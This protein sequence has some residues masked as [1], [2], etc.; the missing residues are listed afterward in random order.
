MRSVAAW[1]TTARE[2]L[3]SVS[4]TAPNTVWF[5]TPGIASVAAENDRLRAGH[6]ATVA[7]SLRALAGT[8][9]DGLDSLDLAEASLVRALA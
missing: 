4:E 8:T 9:R 3:D 2:A 1:L 7:A 5:G 6:A